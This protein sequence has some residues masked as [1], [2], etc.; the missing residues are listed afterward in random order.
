MRDGFTLGGWSV[1]PLE[2]KFERGD[3]VARVQPK[4]MDVL[5]A[6]A[7]AYPS[8]AERDELL[9]R[10]W[11][12][13]AMSDEPL[14]RCI[15]ELRKALGDP[16][17]D[18]Q[19]ILT[20]PKRGYRLIIEPVPMRLEDLAES[21]QPEQAKS[22]K[23]IRVG[24]R[25]LA[26]AVVVAAVAAIVLLFLDQS[27]HEPSDEAAVAIDADTDRK[28]DELLVL[29]RN[30]AAANGT[31]LD[32]E[33]DAAIENAVRAIIMSGNA[34][35]RE[36][37]DMIEDGD[38]RAAAVHL[39]SVA[40]GQASAVSQTGNVAAETWREAGAL[41]YTYD[42]AEAVRAYEHADALQPDDPDTLDMLGYSLLRADRRDD[43]VDIFERLLA[44]QPGAPPADISSALAGLGFVAQEYG[45]LDRA[46]EHLEQARQVAA[47]AGLLE[48]EALA[49]I[50]L[51]SLERSQ[52]SFDVAK[53]DLE[54]ALELATR[55]GIPRYR[56]SALQGLGLTA[57]RQERF[58]VAESHLEDALAINE[59]INDL[60]RQ[61]TT[62]SNLGAVA[63][64]RGDYTRAEELLKQ[65]ASLAEQ[66]GWR[67]SLAYDL[68]NL[69]H[70]AMERGD[71]EAGEAH[72]L[73][74]EVIAREL[75][76]VEL[77]G[78]IVFNRGEIAVIRGDIDMACRHW[79]EALPL[80]D[81]AGGLHTALAEERLDEQ[82]CHR[83]SPQ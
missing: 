2:G 69:G 39:A 16:R 40:E 22:H 45:D 75:N 27:A 32:I 56:A 44:L 68:T 80:L 28:V 37:V 18:P 46:R 70:L 83:E 15:G 5:L 8:V 57:V 4:S 20:V 54:K 23:R 71:A 30:Q 25:R 55:A 81:Q 35:K 60:A 7:E 66:L 19:H 50:L 73:R 36:A 12:G 62:I 51:A 33:S 10:V 67:S 42:F 31:I 6:L 26:Y 61:N 24:F 49:L 41:F 21:A 65:A 17:G 47:D 14:T 9:E 13:R 63:L 79:L 53:Y 34:Q 59:A 77:L 38:V 82:G 3:A 43:A 48:E 52:G 58:D 78:S 11:K 1:Y 74:A 72:L 29:L 64:S 76:I